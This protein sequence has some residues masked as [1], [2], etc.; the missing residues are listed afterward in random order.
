MAWDSAGY[1]G[2][3]SATSHPVPWSSATGSYRT[4]LTDTENNKGRTTR[5]APKWGRIDAARRKP[6]SNAQS[7]V[8][9][10]TFTVLVV[11]R[12]YPYL[13]SSSQG[14][15]SAHCPRFARVF[16][17]HPHHDRLV[18]QAGNATRVPKNRFIL[19]SDVR[20][21]ESAAGWG[22]P[23]SS[24]RRLL[25]LPWTSSGPIP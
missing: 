10:K 19:A 6:F 7:C 14:G 21:L 25:A 17:F 12:R 22:L 9:H 4:L 11:Q 23:A 8:C 2:R 15:V 5:P 3:D 24:R 16:S 1:K 20:R 13:A 18:E